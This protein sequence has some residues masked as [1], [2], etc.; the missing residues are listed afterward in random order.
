MIELALANNLNIRS[1]GFYDSKS[2]SR[3]PA[4]L[5]LHWSPRSP[6]VRKVMIMAHELGLADRLECVRSATAMDVPNPVLMIDN[7]LSK[8]PTLV[9]ENGAAIYDSLVICQYLVGL[10]DAEAQTPAAPASLDAQVRHSLCDGLIDI[11]VLWR[12]ERDKPASQQ[13]R[14]WL[15]AFALKSGAALD[16]LETLA[17]VFAREPFGM[18]HAA[19]G[20]C[21]AYMD[22]RLPALDWRRTRPALAA[23]QAAFSER[24]SARATEITDV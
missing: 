17:P 20:A 24:P 16:R 13:R 3:G 21:L 18:D 7:P 19:L 22:F 6:Y 23:W 10:A 11:I 14:E 8:I 12:N 5:K 4:V 15:D 9:L 2:A 1:Y